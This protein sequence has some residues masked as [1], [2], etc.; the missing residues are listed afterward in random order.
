MQFILEQKSQYLEYIGKK[1]TMNDPK[2]QCHKGWGKISQEG[3]S[4]ELSVLEVNQKF[5]IEDASTKVEAL[6]LSKT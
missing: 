2:L 6:C 4:I 5:I 1:M 3:K